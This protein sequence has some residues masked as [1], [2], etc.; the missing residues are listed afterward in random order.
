MATVNL[1]TDYILAGEHQVMV[2]LASPILLLILRRTSPTWGD[3][4]VLWGTL[5][6]FARSYPTAAVPALL[7]AVLLGIR[8]VS[9]RGSRRAMVIRSGAL[10]LS[11]ATAAIAIVAVLNPR[12]ATNREYFA[13][14]HFMVLHPL[15]LFPSA[16]SLSFLLGQVSQRALWRRSWT[17]LAVGFLLAYAP[18]AF[19]SE[20]GLRAHQS[21]AA[22]TGTATV[23][24]L[25]LLVTVA[26]HRR[27]TRL[28]AG[29][30]VLLAA[31]VLM[32][33]QQSV[34]HSAHWAHYR[35]EMLEV[36]RSEVG[37]VPVERTRL[38]GHPCRWGWTSPYL[39]V[40]WSYPVVR[41]IVENPVGEP[42]QPF[43]PRRT[44]VLRRY[45]RYD[46]VFVMPAT[47]S[48]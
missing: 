11:L 31:I 14:A 20:H 41:A 29:S 36:L 18:F 2:L 43:D 35:D 44:F 37:Y 4:L 46:P 22:R 3:G 39:S 25:L 23:L 28:G 24:P 21:V 30:K 16:A 19:A 42:W 5:L 9:E 15:I 27:G 8:L 1:P 38:H 7:F 40:V 34:R 13:I 32:V 12:D 6:A 33:V 45:V 17:V 26:L 10:L 48:R 47:E